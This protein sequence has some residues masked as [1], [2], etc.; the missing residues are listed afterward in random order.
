MASLHCLVSLHLTYVDDKNT[1][2][3][4]LESLIILFYYNRII[5]DFEY[6][7]NTE[8]LVIGI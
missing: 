6:F 3:E 7:T 5:T 8:T 2:P 1:F 4:A